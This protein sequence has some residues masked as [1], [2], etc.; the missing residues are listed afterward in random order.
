MRSFVL[1]V[2]LKKT[3]LSLK[4]RDKSP[5]SALRHGF[6]RSTYQEVRLAPNPAPCLD[7]ENFSLPREG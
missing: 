6:S 7:Y 3:L 1:L 5:Y 4:R 2:S